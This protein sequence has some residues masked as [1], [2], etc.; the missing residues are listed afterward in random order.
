MDAAMQRPQIEA[1]E[2][3]DRR[4]DAQRA[5]SRRTAAV[6]TAIAVAFFAGVIAAQYSGSPVIGIGVL[7]FAIVGFLIVAIGRNVHK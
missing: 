2:S 5:A 4:R 3:P 6:L 7:M 1:G